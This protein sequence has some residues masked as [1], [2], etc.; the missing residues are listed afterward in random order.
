MPLDTAAAVVDLIFE[1][2]P[3]Q[4]NIDIGFFG[5]EPILEFD[6]IK[7]ITSMIKLH[8]LYDAGRVTLSVV[9]NGTLFSQEIAEFINAQEIE[10]CISCDGPQSVQDCYRRFRDGRGSSAA[11][12]ETIKRAVNA[13]PTVMVN[14]VYTPITVSRLSETVEYFSQLGLKR[15]FLSPDYSATWTKVDIDSLEHVYGEVAEKYV[16]HYLF[17]SPLFINIID[18]KITVIL[19]GGYQQIERCRMGTGEL[20]FAPSGN[21]YPCER[22]IGGDDGSTHCIGNVRKG[23]DLGRMSCH[24]MA[25]EEVNAECMECG[26]RDY[27][28]NWCGCSNY[29]S[30]GYYNRV[31]SFLCASEQMSV[32]TAFG[33]F[34][35]LERELGGVFMEHLAGRP[36]ANVFLKK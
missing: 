29:F 2:T 7:S 25:G 10:F 15:L 32:K 14:A 35:E 33:V 23:M 24:T 19:R 31:G 22:L 6:L 11:V 5:G 28:M 30:S 26:I 17:G 36:Y 18:N 3:P 4:E 34:Q 16:E 1:R 21:I 12:E 9:T 13:F 27:C 20:A 8:R